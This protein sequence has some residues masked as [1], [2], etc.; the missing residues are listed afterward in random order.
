MF[1][2]GGR[3]SRASSLGDARRLASGLTSDLEQ[4]ARDIASASGQF[5]PASASFG[6]NIS[7][8]IDERSWPV[9]AP[10]NAASVSLR[11]RNCS[12]K[13]STSERPRFP[14][15]ANPVLNTRDRF[16]GSLWRSLSQQWAREWCQIKSGW[17]PPVVEQMPQMYRDQTDVWLFF[18]G[19]G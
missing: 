6:C 2:V 17:A 16:I 7:G 12:S 5:R 9:T 11:Y 1:D 19:G 4:A 3:V 10:C 8:A 18:G 15:H 14:P 13:N